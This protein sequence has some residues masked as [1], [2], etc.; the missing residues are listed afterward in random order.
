MQLIALSILGGP[1]ETDEDARFKALH[2]DGVAEECTAS[3]V[4]ALHTVFR[5]SLQVRRCRGAAAGAS[6]HPLRPSQ[7]SLAAHLTAE[8]CSKHNPC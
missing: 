6:A 3:E 8:G 2:L 5:S 7:G 4:L 1:D